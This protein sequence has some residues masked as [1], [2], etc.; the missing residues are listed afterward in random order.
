MAGHK[1]FALASAFNTLCSSGD[2]V[3]PF[4]DSQ[5]PAT[6]QTTRSEAMVSLPRLVRKNREYSGLE[7]GRQELH[8]R[9]HCCFDQR[10]T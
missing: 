5:A 4:I 1:G 7:I 9:G 10:V 8:L 3:I 2:M 6:T